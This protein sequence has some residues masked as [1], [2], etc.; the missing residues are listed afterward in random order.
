MLYVSVGL[1]LFASLLV[2]NLVKLQIFG[3]EKYQS[4]VYDQI[5]TTSKMRAKRGNIYDSDMNVLA[6]ENTSWRIFV[7]TKDI[8]KNEKKT[9]IEYKKIIASGLSSILNI[10]YKTLLEK[11]SGTSKLDVT[12]KNSVSEEEYQRIINFIEK[13]SLQS[14]IFSEAQSS[15]YYPE[16]TLAAH[17][18][19]FTGSDNQGLYGL[20]YYYDK[21][22]KGIDGYYFYA[23]DAN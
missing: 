12:I 9:G 7:S 14:M 5:T 8:R 21:L 15:R 4:K 13:H 1:I 6:T 10:P 17:V 3:S 19:G 23:K 18:L 11:L 22:L 16:E 20:E 2:G